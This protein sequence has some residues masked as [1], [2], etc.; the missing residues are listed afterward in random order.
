MS[1]A[2][3]KA[4]ETL[5]YCVID[6][7]VS[8]QQQLKGGSLDDQEQI[9]RQLADRSGWVVLKVFR[10][11]HSA[12]TL[13]RDDIDEILAWIKASKIPVHFYIVKSI[14]RFTRVGF[15]E[16]EHLKKEF[17]KLGV[18]IVDSYGIIQEKQNTL[19]HLED[20]SYSWSEHY[21]SEVGEMFAAHHAK[22]EVRDILTRLV[23]AEIR[24]RREGY[25]VRRAPDGMENVKVLVGNR[26]KVIRVSGTRAHYFQKMFEWRADGVDDQEIVDRLN[27]MGFRTQETHHWD[28]SDQEH[29]R[30][31]GKRGGNPV[32]VK[33]LQRYIQQTE[34][35]GVIY[36]K[37]TK[38]NPVRAQYEGLVS[39]DLY[40]RANKGK[41]YIKENDD[42]TIEILFDYSPWSKMKRL[43]DNPDYPW[44]CVVCPFCRL[45]MLGSSS[46]GKSGKTYGAY[47]CGGLSSGKRSHQ[48]YRIP[49]DD[50]DQKVCT[51]LDA[52]KFQDG[53]LA[54][55][56]LHLIDQYRSREKEI[57]LQ[58][59]AISR[60]V[61][62]L[63]A[64][65]AKKVA[66][67]EDAKSEVMR[68]TLEADVEGLDQEIKQAEA[69][70]GKV[71]I[72][73]KSIRAFRQYAK[74]VM[75]HPA[76]ILTNA[77]NLY[78]RRLLMSLF[79]EV[80]PTYDEICN[81]TPKLDSLFKLSE[82]FKRN[83]GHFVTPRGI[84]PRFDP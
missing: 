33:Q 15:A 21:P 1:V 51:Y 60:N 59:S 54:G 25:A 72:T 74:K 36:E 61:S 2:M 48:F 14:D 82:D 79:F 38:N 7:R 81:G 78:N 3:S 49:R 76:E 10:K 13:V 37:W 43:R 5:K 17:A 28:R 9:G 34:Y 83:N 73:E 12:T 46:R 23:G 80:T 77:G 47:H 39:V 52:L 30:V 8:D 66:A 29:P 53:F 70:R 16:Y 42:G 6:C 26:K 20:I 69:V 58:S 55:L 84:E 24:L 45:E 31:V 19:G 64:E 63:K 56:E 65:L 18:S 11:P 32:T 22:Q 75:E 35:A 44:K 27:A 71:E 67:F 57:L 62:D 40:N 4:T 68:R 50:F 41:K